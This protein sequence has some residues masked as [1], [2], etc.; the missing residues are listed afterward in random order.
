MKFNHL[1]T[2][3]VV[4]KCVDLNVM[5]NHL[6]KNVKRYA[7]EIDSL[8]IEKLKTHAETFGFTFI[9]QVYIQRL[10]PSKKL[11]VYSMVLLY[12]GFCILKIF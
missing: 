3:Y 2:I 12:H 5:D 11:T 1:M 4:L 7:L 8:S 6:E 10:S 9:T